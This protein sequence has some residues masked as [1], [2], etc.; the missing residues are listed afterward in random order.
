LF[1][2]KK[3][4]CLLLQCMPKTTG[5]AEV[6]VKIGDVIDVAQMPATGQGVIESSGTQLA[7]DS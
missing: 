5:C 2:A 6:E 4:E 1:N 7:P 3:Q